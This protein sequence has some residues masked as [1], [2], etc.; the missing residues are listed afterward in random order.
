MIYYKNLRDALSE[1]KKRGGV[2]RYD[3]K[4]EMYYICA[5]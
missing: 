2:L 1:L 3:T 5:L 4:L